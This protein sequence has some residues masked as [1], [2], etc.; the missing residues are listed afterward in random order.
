MS[1]FLY[2]GDAIMRKKGTMAT[3]PQEISDPNL[4]FMLLRRT[5]KTNAGASM[6]SDEH[7]NPNGGSRARKAGTY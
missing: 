4:P 6:N 1:F 3:A 7:R 5:R 2:E